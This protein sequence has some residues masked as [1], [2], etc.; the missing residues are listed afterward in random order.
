MLCMH[1]SAC[2]QQPCGPN[3]FLSPVV[4][5]TIAASSRLV[6]CSIHDDG[7]ETPP[8]SSVY[9]PSGH[10]GGFRSCGASSP[11]KHLGAFAHELL[12]CTRINLQAAWL[13]SIGLGKP[14]AAHTHPESNPHHHAAVKV[15]VSPSLPPC[16]CKLHRK[17]TPSLPRSPPP[18]ADHSSTM[19]APACVRPAP[20]PQQLLHLSHMTDCTALRRRCWWPTPPL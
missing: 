12:A 5:T 13:I 20:A 17:H 15:Y 3:Q 16:K 1:A 4:H 9:C 11:S 6:L 18:R 14:A 7:H 10:A 2:A 19:Y 8:C